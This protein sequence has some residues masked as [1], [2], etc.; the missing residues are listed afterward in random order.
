MFLS[1]KEGGNESE[2]NYRSAEEEKSFVRSNVWEGCEYHHPSSSS[3]SF[4]SSLRPNR[5]PPIPSGHNLFPSIV[6][7]HIICHFALNL[8]CIFCQLKQRVSSTSERGGV[9]QSRIESLLFTTMR[10]SVDLGLCRVPTMNQ[11]C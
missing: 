8:P 11:G 4:L 7:R 5:N 6:L 3:S 10:C 2:V 9:T 1:P